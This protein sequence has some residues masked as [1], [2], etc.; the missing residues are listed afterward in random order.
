MKKNTNKPGNI[1]LHFS[2]DTA[3]KSEALDRLLDS[4]S[5]LMDG[6]ASALVSKPL[7]IPSKGGLQRIR[8]EEVLY[9]KAD[10]NYC[11]IHFLTGQSLL[12]SAPLSNVA[13]HFLNDNFIRIHR[14]YVINMEHLEFLLG[15]TVM[16]INGVQLPVNKEFK[17]KIYNLLEVEGTKSGKYGSGGF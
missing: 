10:R 9:F 1:S 4:L 12:V 14:S 2:I 11:T 5:K 15:N 7:F 13:R 17:K 16:L 6:N 8:K 3:L